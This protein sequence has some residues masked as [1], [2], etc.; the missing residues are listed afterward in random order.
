MEMSMV[1]SSPKDHELNTHLNSITGYLLLQ[2]KKYLTVFVCQYLHMNI[3]GSQEAAQLIH[4]A[5][6]FVNGSH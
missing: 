3:Y 2:S 5:F 6:R 1:T 4:I